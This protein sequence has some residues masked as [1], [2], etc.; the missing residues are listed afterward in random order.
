MGLGFGVRGCAHFLTGPV[1]G[2]SFCQGPGRDID[3]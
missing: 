3:V 1:F 2:L